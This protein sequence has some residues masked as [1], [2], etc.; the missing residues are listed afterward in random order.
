MSRVNILLTPFTITRHIKIV[1]QFQILGGKQ[2]KKTTEFNISRL[3]IREKVCLRVYAYK[4]ELKLMLN[5][6]N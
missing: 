6:K 3:V 1:N 2:K 4:V 5:N